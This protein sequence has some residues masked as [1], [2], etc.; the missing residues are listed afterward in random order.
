[1]F[2]LAATAII[3]VMAAWFA[4]YLYAEYAFDLKGRARTVDPVPAGPLTGRWFDDYFV[5][6]TLDPTT[7]AI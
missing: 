2:F 7:F 1:L 3:V 4:P 6:Q 5:V